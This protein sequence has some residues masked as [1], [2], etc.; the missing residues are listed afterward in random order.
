M[1]SYE[2]TDRGN[3]QIAIEQSRHLDTIARV[4]EVISHDGEGTSTPATDPSAGPDDGPTIDPATEAPPSEVAGSYEGPRVTCEDLY[5][6]N[7]DPFVEIPMLGFVPGGV[8]VPT[9]GDNWYVRV[10]EIPGLG[11]VATQTLYH[12][13]NPSPAGEPGDLRLRTRDMVAELVTD[14]DGDAVVRLGHGPDD[15]GD[16]G[17][18]FIAR[19]DGAIEGYSSANTGFCF[20]PDGTY[21][22]SGMGSYLVTGSPGTGGP[23]GPTSPAGP[24]DTSS[25]NPLVGQPVDATPEV[26]DA[27]VQYTLG[28]G[29]VLGNKRIK[30]GGAGTASTEDV[31]AQATSGVPVS[32]IANG[33]GWRIKNIGIEGLATEAPI[34]VKVT[35]P[36]GYGVIE[37]CYIGG[38]SVRDETNLFV[39]LEH[40]GTLTIRDSTFKNAN[41]S[42]GVYGAPPGS[43]PW[44]TQGAG[45]IVQIE[46]CYATGFGDVGFRL[47]TSSSYV[48][49]SVID[50]RGGPDGSSGN[51]GIWNQWNIGV[52]ENCRIAV[53]HNAFNVGSNDYKNRQVCKLIAKNCEWIADNEVRKAPGIQNDDFYNSTNVTRNPSVDLTSPPGAPTT[54]ADAAGI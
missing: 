40:A 4:T 32:I 42:H 33:S 18:G 26:V 16:M 36:D 21:Y 29:D 23:G 34:T 38:T 37:H 20:L 10:E 41:Y 28:D 7:R 17:S 27:P 46:S 52:A 13:G 51:S 11:P 53:D 49:D 22:Y 15:R 47:G 39:H 30:A 19:A 14:S 9:A 8:A 35:D 50:S 6:Q 5:D 12:E 2:P 48:K 3:T 54:A 1:F 24:T 43:P 45:G 31:S 25:D 44:R